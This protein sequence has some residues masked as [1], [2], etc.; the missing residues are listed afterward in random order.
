MV[1]TIVIKGKFVN[2]E[3]T[4]TEDVFTKKWLVF[5]LSIA[6]FLIPTFFIIGYLHT[7]AI[8]KKTGKIKP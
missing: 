6:L 1:K 3:L 2:G 8:W 5:L 7:L 4:E